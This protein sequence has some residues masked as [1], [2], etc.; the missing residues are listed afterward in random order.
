MK[1]NNKPNLFIVGAPRSGTTSL[2]FYLKQHDEIFFPQVK[3]PRHFQWDYYNDI[4]YDKLKTRSYSSK[5]DYLDLFQTEKKFKYYAEASP[6]YLYAYDSASQIK[7]EY[8]DAKILIILRNPIDRCFSNYTL[9]HSSGRE[10]L[11]FGECI[12]YEINFL[13]D[14]REGS[15]HYIRQ[16]FYSN[17]IKAYQEIFGDSVEVFLYDDLKKDSNLLISSILDFLDLKETNKINTNFITQQSK[18]NKPKFFQ[19]IKKWRV[20]KLLF[21]LIPLNWRLNLKTYINDSFLNKEYTMDI[22]SRKKLENLYRE[23]IIRTSKLIDK[24]L[25]HWLDSSIES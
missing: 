23:D 17:G 14:R 9:R 6:S 2:Y 5:N 13:K 3:E 24:D 12:D 8:P 10:K 18:I 7:M 19:K 15:R 22:T 21:S 25:N 1:Y 11:T 16:G 4:F 20:K